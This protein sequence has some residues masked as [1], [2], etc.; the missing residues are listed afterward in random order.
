[1]DE[2]TNEKPPNDPVTGAQVI[3][4][5]EVIATRGTGDVERFGE[6]DR[7]RRVR[8]Y[9]SKGGDLLAEHDHHGT[10]VL[11][12]RVTLA[13]RARDEALARCPSRT[14][15]ATIEFWKNSFAEQE[16]ATARIR[17]ACAKLRAE[18]KRLRERL[19]PYRVDEALSKRGALTPPNLRQRNDRAKRLR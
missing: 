13:E 1:M 6:A 7:A 17:D 2:T 4:V 16:R 14:T 10:L 11:R 12:D 9:F 18:N 3:E 8:R 15:D 19:K 5:I